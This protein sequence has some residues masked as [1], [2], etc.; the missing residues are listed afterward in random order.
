MSDDARKAEAEQIG[1]MLKK[2]IGHTAELLVKVQ[3]ENA[4][5]HA[6]AMVAA[7]L[8]SGDEEDHVYWVKI[9]KEVDKRLA[10]DTYDGVPDSAPPGEV[11]DPGATE[12][13]DE[14]KA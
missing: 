11:S 2:E 1:R 10:V 3:R 13:T 7:A 12:Q 9:A 5:K 6:A 8:K 4:G 14:I